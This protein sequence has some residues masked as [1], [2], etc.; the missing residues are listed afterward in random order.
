MYMYIGWRLSTV[1]LRRPAAN[2]RGGHGPR[3]AGYGPYR[4]GEANT[5]GS[6]FD[7]PI[8]SLKTGVNSGDLAEPSARKKNYTLWR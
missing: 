4:Q 3:Q 7:F 2:H 5:D 8:F 6:A 1:V